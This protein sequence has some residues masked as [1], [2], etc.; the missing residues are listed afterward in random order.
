LEG[1]AIMGDPSRVRVLGPLAPYAEGFGAELGRLGYTPLS[2]ANQL[3]VLAHLS[4]W[5]SEQGLDAAG[6]TLVTLTKFLAARRAAGYTSWLSARGL[7]PLLG[8]LREV[9]AAPQPVAVVEVAPIEVLLGR[10]RDY[11]LCERGLTAGT[12]RG[13]VD[14]VRPFV[15]ARAG[16]EGLGIETLTAAEVS[17]FVLGAVRG[18]CSG[19]AKLL[20]TALRSL[21]RFLHVAGDLPAALDAAVPSAAVWR[22][23]GLPQALDEGQLGAL[24][25]GCDRGTATR[26]RDTAILALLARLG[27]RRGEVAAL[28]LQDIDWRAGE[29][30]IRGKG[31]RQL[32]LPLPFDVGEAVVA[33]LRER[34]VSPGCRAVFVAARAPYRA[35]SPEGVTAVVTR[36]GHRGGLGSIGA[37]RLRHTA[38]TQML[39]AG[40]PLSEI[41]QLLRH[42]SVSSTAIYAKVDRDALAALARPWPADA[43]PADAQPADVQPA[44]AR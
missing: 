5:L 24:L 16:A 33:Y 29:I 40:A 31:D 10:Y 36:A 18:R 38:A 4:R 7:V 21:L 28:S 11:L 14:L 9:G 17:G 3:R 32:P 44:D 41:G 6:L 20:M 37:H 26:G 25:D 15:V 1:K 23:A 19:S 35:L 22:L 2:A 43:Q 42:R 13:Y 39:R 27:L 8:Y 34:P 30:T 12:V